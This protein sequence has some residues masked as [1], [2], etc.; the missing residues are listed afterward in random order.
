[1][2]D[3][4]PK[5]IGKRGAEEAQVTKQ[6]VPGEAKRVAGRK[7]SEHGDDLTDSDDSDSHDLNTGDDG[8]KRERR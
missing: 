6:S 1:M 2:A 8:D 7:A 4:P 5:L 3:A